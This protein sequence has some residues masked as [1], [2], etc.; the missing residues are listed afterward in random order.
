MPINVVT[1]CTYSIN[2]DTFLIGFLYSFVCLFV[3]WMVHMLTSFWEHLVVW[4]FLLLAPLNSLATISHNLGSRIMDEHSLTIKNSFYLFVWAYTE[5]I[6]PCC[7][8]S[9]YLMSLS[10]WCAF[11]C[12]FL[13]SNVFKDNNSSW[14]HFHS[15]EWGWII[16]VPLSCFLTWRE[17][18]FRHAWVKDID[19][20]FVPT[21]FCRQQRLVQWYW[22]PSRHDTSNHPKGCKTLIHSPKMICIKNK[23]K[24]DFSLLNP[25][26]VRL[27]ACFPV[28]WLH[29]R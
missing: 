20:I 9:H 29:H 11:I 22:R 17:C 28:G 19:Y 14:E 26:T 16:I 18:F 12:H 2:V 8:L 6:F 15:G 21:P 24:K 23:T 10:L 25:S 3:L 5:S 4:S 27:C 7:L 13:V 1:G